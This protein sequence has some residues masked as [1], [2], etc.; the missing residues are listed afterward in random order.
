MNKTCTALTLLALAATAQA[1]NKTLTECRAI[2]DATQR[3]ACYDAL[4]LPAVVAA[5]RFGL[6]GQP[7]PA[8]PDEVRSQ[9]MGAFEGWGPTT[10]FTLA[11]GQRWRVSDGSSAYW[12]VQDPKVTIS[13]G[14]LGGFNFQIEGLNKTAKVRRVN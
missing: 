7:D 12:R 14:M 3:L 10:I 13:R 6:E 2:A 8:A 11:N 5:Q 9:I 4:A 1:Q